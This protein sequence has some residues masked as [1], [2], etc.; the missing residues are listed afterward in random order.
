MASTRN[1]FE[2][3]ALTETG[4]GR[5]ENQDRM[6]GALVPLGHLY[7]V[8][9][10]MGGHMGGA[11][12]AKLTVDGLQTHLSEA[13]K[14]ASVERNIREAF[15]KANADV[16]RQ[17]VSGD[18]DTQGMGSTAVLLLAADSHAYI[19]HVGDSR[20]YLFRARKMQRL[21]KDHTQVQKM[22]DAGILSEKEARV[23][24]DA[25]VLARAMGHAASIAVDFSELELEEGD[26]VLLCSDGLSGYVDDS[27]I[28][29]ILR[30][31]SSVQEIPRKLVSLALDKGGDDNITVQYIR[32]GERAA[33][34]LEEKP[35]DRQEGETPPA[36]GPRVRVGTL[37]LA[38]AAGAALALGV[39]WLADALVGDAER[40]ERHQL[41]ETIA[42]LEGMI[43][44]LEGKIDE[45]EGDLAAAQDRIEDLEAAVDELPGADEEADT[46]EGGEP[47][48]E[49]GNEPDS[50]NDEDPFAMD[51]S[52]NGDSL[53]VAETMG[54]CGGFVRGLELDRTFS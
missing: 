38:F 40:A 7:I 42:E 24:P 26:A 22:I 9:D 41:N 34:K 11:N 29:E 46:E 36:A 12:A 30:S 39:T 28:E 3:G 53:I 25:S 31:D 4:H 19:A 52:S 6:S 21:T 35:A 48:V 49:E 10:G 5:Q 32:Y 16:Y 45:L 2:V 20:A 17:A 47:G 33:K 15:Q 23:H 8:A 51:P 43:A 18:P 44:E 50:G 27:E 37:L 14:G 54:R 13:P 1:K